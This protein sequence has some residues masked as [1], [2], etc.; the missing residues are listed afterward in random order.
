MAFVVLSTLACVT[1]SIFQCTPIHKAWDLTGRVS[2]SCI[3]V[4]ALFFANAGLDIFQDTLIY[5]LPMRMLYQLQVPK[6]QKI[7]LMMV[8]AVGGFV[9]ITG[10]I[11]LNYLKVAQ[12]TP[13]PSCRH[14]LSSSRSRTVSDIFVDDN[15]GGAVWSAI[16]CNI[17]VVCASLPAFKPL[18]DRFFPSL[19]GFGQKGPSKTAPPG[20]PAAGKRGYI[21]N[22]GQSEFEL[23]PRAA[24]KDSSKSKYGGDVDYNSSATAEGRPTSMATTNDEKLRSANPHGKDSRGIWKST[25]VVVRHDGV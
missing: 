8:F 7:A 12:N 6:R 19:M 13:D 10:M 18:I 4:N 21:R 25:S 2:G 23:G 9:V 14:F 20:T 24:W 11:R 1:A 15:Y 5:V 17:G 3:D 22:T 16:E